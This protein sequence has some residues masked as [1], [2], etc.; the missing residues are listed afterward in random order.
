MERIESDRMQV[1]EEVER[2][3]DLLW[4]SNERIRI[5]LE[6]RDR[7]EPGL[8]RRLAPICTSCEIAMTWSRSALGL[9][10][11]QITHVFAC[12]R[13]GKIT[14]TEARAKLRFE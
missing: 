13:C 2:T 6:L 11:R 8:A 4:R 1:C 12:P 7:N 14:E 10:R 9:R 5:S 3:W